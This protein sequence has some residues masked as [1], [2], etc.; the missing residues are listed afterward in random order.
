[1]LVLKSGI[2]YGVC[3]PLHSRSEACSTTATCLMTIDAHGVAAVVKPSNMAIFECPKVRDLWFAS[4]C[5]M[6]RQSASLPSMCDAIRAWSAC[7]KGLVSKGAFLAWVVWGERNNHVFNNVSTP[8]HVLLA[9]VLRPV[10]E[11]GAYSSKIYSGRGVVPSS[12]PRIWKAPP[13]GTIKL[14]IDASLAIDGWVGLGVVA[15]NCDGDVSFAVTRRV[16]ANWTAEVA[17]AKGIELAVRLCRRYGLQNVVIESDCLTVINRLSKHVIFLSDL[18]IVL[19]NIF[20]SSV[21]LSSLI[22][23]HVKRDGNVVAHN[24]ARIISFG[25]E[26]IWEDHSPPEVAPYVLMDKLS[27]E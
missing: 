3:A 24:L 1:M 9:R 11:H 19:H 14:N 13:A 8:P 2:F 10:E 20:A 5:E 27:M 23:S 15:R 7:D 12:R 17:E 4:G 6:V 21:H 16:R 18:D 26:Q 25:V 22:W